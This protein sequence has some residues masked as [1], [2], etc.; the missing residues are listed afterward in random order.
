MG[1]M[2]AIENIS[3]IT[4]ENIS[5]D[6]KLFPQ[7]GTGK[8]QGDQGCKNLKRVSIL[9]VKVHEIEIPHFLDHDP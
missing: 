5:R 2:G 7:P 3:E 1:E 6:K 8:G 9:G 4:V